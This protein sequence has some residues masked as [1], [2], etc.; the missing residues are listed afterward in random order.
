MKN[1]I[2]PKMALN[3]QEPLSTIGLS[4]PPNPTTDCEATTVKVNQPLWTTLDKR[5]F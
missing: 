2:L 5:L 4:L 1:V 3:Q